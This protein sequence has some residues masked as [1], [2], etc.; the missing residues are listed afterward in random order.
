MSYA[1]GFKLQ[2]WDIIV[3]EINLQGKSKR[4]LKIKNRF[5]KALTI[6]TSNCGDNVTKT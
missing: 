2:P 6:E 4:S 3:V 5:R 1:L